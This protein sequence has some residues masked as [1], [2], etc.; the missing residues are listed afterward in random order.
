MYNPSMKSVLITGVSSGIGNVLVRKLIK[1]D[2]KV[3]GI[4]R[5]KKLLFQLSN[6]LNNNKFFYTAADVSD[7]NF[8]QGLIK[9]LSRKRFIPEVI[10]FNAAL[11][12]NDFQEKIEMEKLRKIMEVNFFSILEGVKLFTD[13]YSKMHFICISST[14]AFKGNFKEGIGYSASKGALSIAFESLFQKYINSK[15]VFTTVFFGPV[16]TDMIRFSKFP[17]MT[18]TTDNAADYI[19]KAI[20]EKKPFYYYPKLG[21]IFLKGLR[22]L[23][24]EIFF[25]LWVAMQKTYTKDKKEVKSAY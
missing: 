17:P 7:R 11:N 24:N 22:L 13:K 14:S 6:E 23:P 9:D 18:L 25:K 8:W 16:K 12:E 1:S 10:I 2:F 19:I 20:N 21:F 5:R 15:I 4:A 3:W